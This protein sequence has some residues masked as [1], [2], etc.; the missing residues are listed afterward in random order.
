MKKDD[1][2]WPD[3]IAALRRLDT[4]IQDGTNK[5]DRV[6]TLIAACIAMGVG[7]LD[8][9]EGAVTACGYHRAHVLIR[10]A[11]NTGPDPVAKRWWH[12]DDGC[13]HNH[14]D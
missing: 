3:F 9:I 11:K 5:H 14:P 7:T 13:Y 1:N 2:F 12:D 4:S 6:D 10:L 8:C